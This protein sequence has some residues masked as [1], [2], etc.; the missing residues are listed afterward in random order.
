MLELKRYMRAGR[1]GTED[2]DVTLSSRTN[3]GYGDG[4]RTRNVPDVNDVCLRE[5]IR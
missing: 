5:T 1:E 2:K 3:G 4:L